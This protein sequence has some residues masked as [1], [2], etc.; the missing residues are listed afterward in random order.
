MYQVRTEIVKNCSV[1]A[2][3]IFVADND[4]SFLNYFLVNKHGRI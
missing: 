4:F 2:H 3:E 1:S